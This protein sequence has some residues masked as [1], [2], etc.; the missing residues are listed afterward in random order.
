MLAAR[1]LTFPLAARTSVASD[2]IVKSTAP[3]H[4]AI[5]QH[6]DV[7]VVGVHAVQ[8][9]RLSSI[10]TVPNHDLMSRNREH[11]QRS[12]PAQIRLSPPAAYKPTKTLT[13]DRP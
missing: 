7:S 1:H 2:S 13:P 8:K 12:L 11:H 9:R 5:T 6:H 3:T 4:R 10:N